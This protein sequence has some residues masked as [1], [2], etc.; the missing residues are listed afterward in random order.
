MRRIGL[1]FTGQ[2]YTIPQIVSAGKAA[3]A[4]GFAAVWT[5]E[6]YWTGRDGITPLA[7][8]ALNTE[9]V[10]LGNCVINPYNRH[11]ML[12]AMTLGNLATVAH[13]RIALGIGAGMRWQPLMPEAFEQRPP[14]RA[15]KECVTLVRAV[16]A[17]ERVAFGQEQW[18]L[19]LNRPAFH[20]GSQFQPQS[21]PVYLG[22]YGPQTMRLIGTIG[23]GFIHATGTKPSEMALR[24]QQLD[25]AARR[26]GRDPAALDR[27]SLIF[28]SASD[29]GRIHP[30]V[31]NT[32][33][34]AVSRLDESE[35]ASLGL[36]PE[37]VARV[38]QARAAGDLAGARDLIDQSMVSLVAAAGTPEQCLRSLERYAQ[39]GVTLPMLFAFGG[40]L[41]PL[42]EV[43]ATFARGE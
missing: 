30:N 35:I 37:R 27:A 13:G 15:L 4:A 9:R 32:A 16:F 18:G 12:I 23:D 41:E 26:A 3:D 8:L 39:A 25:A 10:Q 24:N 2:P 38:C 19:V 34:G 5:A 6:D 28:A 11:P 21:I 29:D 20:D 36:D 40:D 1:A 7:C 33:V 17:G 14:L 42:V 43:G 22:G 31:L